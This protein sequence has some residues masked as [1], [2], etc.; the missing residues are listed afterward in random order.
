MPTPR[1]VHPD[2][3]FRPPEGLADPH[4]LPSRQMHIRW[5]DW[6]HDQIQRHA[7]FEG[8]SM[9]AW[10]RTRMRKALLAEVMR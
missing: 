2:D 8:M 7:R 10:V 5:N 6:E 4:G 1:T 3:V 9:Q